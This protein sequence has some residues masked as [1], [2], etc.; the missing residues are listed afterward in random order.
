MLQIEL[1]AAGDLVHACD[2]FCEIVG[3]DEVAA[4]LQ[5]SLDRTGRAL[6]ETT[7]RGELQVFVRDVGVLLRTRQREL[8]F[9][10]RLRQDEPRVVVAGRE[11]LAHRRIG[12]EAREVRRLE[13][14][15]VGVEPE[16]R[17]PGDD[18]NGMVG[19]NGIPVV[20]AL[21]VVPHAVAI[22]QACARFLGDAEHATVDVGG[23]AG[24]HRLRC[25]PETFR[26]PVLA[27]EFVVVADAAGRHDDRTRSD[28]EVA[29]LVAVRRLAAPGG[30]RGEL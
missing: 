30:G 17:R 23:D 16:R 15:A 25:G 8:L 14:I 21:G 24:D 11:D 22:D 2:E 18:A 5:K 4:V 27:D 3:D 28:L 29:D 26:R 12:I 1:G 13:A 19:P 10:D 7:L 20:D 9:D 6:G